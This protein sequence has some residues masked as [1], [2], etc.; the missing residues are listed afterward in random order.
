MRKRTKI[1]LGAAAAAALVTGAAA[2]DQRLTVRTYGVYSDKLT[3]PVRLAVLADLHSCRYGCGQTELL[4]ALE[5]AK[6]DAVLLPGDIVDDDMPEGPAW[7]LLTALVQRWPA[8]YV[9]GNH[10]WWGGDAERIKEEIDHLGIWV[11]DGAEADLEL[12]GQAI[13]FLG[14]DDPAAGSLYGE[15]HA[16]LIAPRDPEHFTV[17]LAHRPERWAEYPAL[18]ADLTVNGH[19]HGGQWRLPGLVDGV[20]APDQ[21][22]LPK[23]A[24]GLY[25]HDGMTQI[26]SRGLARESTRVPRLFNRPELVVVELTPKT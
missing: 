22:L 23:Y 19:A 17:L 4:S 2:L 9:T 18:G 26:V 12:N 1:I 21:G 16:A 14:L 24:G 20:F 25:A 13:R 8:C 10:E 15:E 7:D 3:A 11:L 5:H 6:P